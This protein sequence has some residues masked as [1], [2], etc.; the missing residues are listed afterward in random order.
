MQVRSPTSPA[1]S[2]ADP[3]PRAGRRRRGG[4]G[5]GDGVVA[6]QPRQDAAPPEL[7][8]PLALRS[9]QHH[10]G[11]LPMYVNFSFSPLSANANTAPSHGEISF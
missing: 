11:R 10:P 5:G 1:E 3:S 8:Q 7:P 9:H 4:G 6:G 2:T